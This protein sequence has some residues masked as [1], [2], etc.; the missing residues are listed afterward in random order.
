MSGYSCMQA[1]REAIDKVCARG[2]VTMEVQ[3]AA[4]KVGEVVAQVRTEAD[5]SPNS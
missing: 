4:L 2:N 1:L 3:S 5:F